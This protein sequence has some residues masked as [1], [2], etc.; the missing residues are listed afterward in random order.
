MDVDAV[1][2]GLAK[3]ALEAL[4][5]GLILPDEEEEEEDLGKIHRSFNALSM[6][7]RRSDAGALAEEPECKDD[8]EAE[9]CE[10]EELDPDYDEEFEAE[11][12]LDTPVKAPRRA[13]PRVP[14]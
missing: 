2:A 4:F 14:A 13:P 5:R 6:S 11:P 3:G 10:E 1:L 12:P 8:E 7:L 9:E